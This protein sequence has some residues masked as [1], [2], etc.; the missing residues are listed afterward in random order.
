MAADSLPRLPAATQRLDQRH[1]GGLPVCHGLHQSA[2][3]AQRGGLRG[4]DFGV[5]DLAAKAGVPDG[6]VLQPLNCALTSHLDQLNILLEQ[7]IDDGIV[8]PQ[9]C[10]HRQDDSPASDAW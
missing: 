3:R 4:D 7:V 1:G 5:A 8:R 2:A 6:F 9:C 10:G